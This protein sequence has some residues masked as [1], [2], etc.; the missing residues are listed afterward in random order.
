MFFLTIL[1]P[2]VILKQSLGVVTF[3]RACRQSCY[4]ITVSVGDI[5][6]LPLKTELKVPFVF[7]VL[8]AGEIVCLTSCSYFDMILLSAKCLKLCSFYP[9]VF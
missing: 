6:A 1:H 4:E 8:S 2:V 3:F 7:V 5:L 9:V